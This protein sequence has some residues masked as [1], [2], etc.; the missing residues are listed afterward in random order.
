M[1]SDPIPT[2]DPMLG[3]RDPVTKE[4][5]QQV[6]ECATEQGVHDWLEITIVVLI[7]VLGYARSGML[8]FGIAGLMVAALA[9]LLAD[10]E[11][12]RS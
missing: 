11:R 4:G 5:E 12:Q 10:E 7:L 3:E 9:C 2:S 6:V 8:G 1:T